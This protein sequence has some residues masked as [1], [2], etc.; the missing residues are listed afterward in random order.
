MRKGGERPNLELPFYEETV[1][2]QTV[3]T[4][5]RYSTKKERL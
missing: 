3:A 1:G 4:F 2:N 5:E